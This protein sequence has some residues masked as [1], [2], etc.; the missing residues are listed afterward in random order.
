[1]KTLLLS[2]FVL[3]GQ[4]ASAQVPDW[5]WAAQG[6]NGAAGGQGIARQPNG[7]YT[8]VGH[9]RATLSVGGQ[10]LVSQGDDDV[11]LIQYNATG[12]VQWAKRAG[13]PG[14]DGGTAIASDAAGN[15]YVSG[16]FNGRTDFD[17]TTLASVGGSDDAFL[18]KYSGTGILLWVQQAGGSLPDYATALTLDRAGNVV[19]AGQF[20]G[21]IIFGSTTIG[22]AG[23]SAGFLA[24]YDANGNLQWAQD[25]P[26]SV[27][28][29]VAA[30]DVGE[31]YVAGALAP[32]GGVLAKFD[33]RGALLWTSPACKNAAGTGVA[34]DTKGDVY[35]AGRFLDTL[36]VGRTLLVSRGS[37]DGFIAKF[38]AQG[39]GNWV[40]GIGGANDDEALGVAITGLGNVGVTGYFRGNATVGGQALNNTGTSSGV[41]VSC[42]DP[43]GADLWVRSAAGDSL[44]RGNALDFETNTE[45]GSLT[46]A[47]QGLL[48]FRPVR[49]LATECICH[50]DIFT[51]HLTATFPDLTV[52]TAQAVQGSYHNLS[53]TA[54][55][56]A[57]LAGPLQITGTLTVQSGGILATQCQPLTGPGSFVLEAGAEL[58]ICQPSGI[59]ATGATGAVQV[60]GSRSFSAD[61]SY[62]YNGTAAQQTGPGLPGQV[63]ALE[64]ANAAGLGLT[65]P[66]SI[67]RNLQLTTGNLLT[68]NQLLTLLS[69]ATGTAQVNNA[70]GV[71]QG[72]ATVQRYIDPSLNSGLGYRHFSSPVQATTVADLATSNFTPITNSAYNS[73]P[74]PNPLP[75]ITVQAY[76]EQRL[77]L[78][79]PGDFNQGW[80]SPA[81]TSAPLEVLRGYSVQLAGNQT[82]DFVGTLNTGPYTATL[83]RGAQVDAGWNLVGNPYPSTLDWSRVAIPAGLNAA[84]YVFQSTG[85]YAGRYRTYVNGIG[86]PLIALGQGFMVQPSA[87]NSSVQLALTNAARVAT[88]ATAPP[89]N[90]GT[91]DTRPLVQLV[92]TEA[93]TGQADETTVYFEAG[94]TARAEAGYDAR[95]AAADSVSTV[96]LASLTTAREPLAINGL[97]LPRTACT[98]ALLVQA[99]R[100]GA[101]TLAVAQFTRMAGLTGVLRDAVTGQSLPLRAQGQYA[102]RVVPGE[103]LARRFSLL[104]SPVQ[105]AVVPMRRK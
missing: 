33:S 83:T 81:S 28:G 57:T 32:T 22:R 105:L 95:K 84:M 75:T 101:Y 18:A 87:A 72:T 48:A 46:G 62:V 12:R 53:V 42:Y 68:N 25:L 1:M 45:A 26:E 47:F 64:V 96:R 94:A 70:G 58:H 103:N 2:L 43:L 67:V 34:V 16:Y 49:T 74:P 98:V 61:G 40:N 9:F 8:V 20:Q 4:L 27:V 30:N 50:E 10:T 89:L 104:F 11:L 69:N 14:H 17:G 6:G 41:F 39:N 38:D 55:G 44:A 60:S 3:V 77:A 65:A 78:G 52:S 13:G 59:A 86:N 76:E 19:V 54:T 56:L 7:S 97:P 88:Y 63:R 79:A 21:P 35:V 37:F 85:P 93:A 5:D 80:Y 29:G 15:L 102:F 24:Q 31:L 23:M 71:V 92:L 82:V 99:V 36:P 66:V 100:P 51:A 91:A 73:V 90:R